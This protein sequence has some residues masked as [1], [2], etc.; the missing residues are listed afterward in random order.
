MKLYLSFELAPYQPAIFKSAGMKPSNAIPE[1]CESVIDGSYLLHKVIWSDK[2]SYIAICRRYIKYILDH[3]GHNSNVV[4]QGYQRL[5]ST[6]VSERRHRAKRGASR[7]ILF[8]PDTISVSTQH[9]FLNN[10]LIYL[11]PKL[12]QNIL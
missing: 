9:S 3:Y 4:F 2:S 7:N 11:P 8:E 10:N 12:K 5:E 6:K 1:N